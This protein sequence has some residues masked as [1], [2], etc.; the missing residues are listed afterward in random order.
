M[1]KP[2][3]PL[4]LLWLLIESP[5]STTHVGAMLLFKKPPGRT[6]V[7]REIVDAYRGYRPV[8]P[9]NYVPELVGGGAPHFR[10]V[11]DWD[12]VYHVQHLALPT[13]SSYEDLLRLVA[14][15]HEPMLDRDRPLFRCFVIDSV[16]G[17][18]FAI[19]TKTHH[20]I[21]DGA[22][23]LKMLYAGLSLS[24]EHTVPEPAF[25]LRPPP[26]TARPAVPFVQRITDSVRGVLTQL[27]AV[28]E[29]SMG[30]LRKTLTGLVGAHLE[31]SLPFMAQHAPTNE[32]LKRGRRF[33]TLSLPLEEMRRIGHHFGATLNDV[34][35][36]VV[37][38][39][40]HAYLRETGRAFPHPFIAM[41]PVSLRDDGDAAIGTRASAMF[42]RLGDPAAGAPE[43]LKQVVDSVAAAKAELRGMSSDAAMTYAVGIIALAGL[44]ASTH[45]DRVGR[46]AANLVISNVPGAKETRYLNGA[47][48]LGIYPVSA[49]A[50]SIGLNATLSSY[51]DHMDFGFVANATAIDDLSSLSGHTLQAYEQL[52]AATSE[53]STPR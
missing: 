10:Q 42:V 16:P 2:I 3:P 24:E 1:T 35:V 52:R 12:P 5:V 29:V 51:H 34:A 33:A 18:R 47:R 27:E 11:E 14:E 50:A 48:L 19:Y 22:S 21:V 49:L 7:V 40:L 30:A 23:G 6:A 36:A 31:G 28:N 37:D 8:P 41:C 45:L 4:D 20:C 26:P 9:F 17:G 32:P 53:Q 38:A 13:G 25:A 39:G 46:P 43:R 44:T 15:L